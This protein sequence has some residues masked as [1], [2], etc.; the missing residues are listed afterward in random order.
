MD[1]PAQGRLPLALSRHHWGRDWP[2]GGGDP[3]CV[4]PGLALEA[5]P[6]AL[7][8]RGGAPHPPQVPRL[9]LHQRCA[10]LGRRRLCLL[11]RAPRWGQ[12]HPRDQVLPE[13][14]RHA[15]GAP[16]PHPPVQ[17]RGHRLQRGC[18]AAVREGGPHDPQWG[19]RRRAHGSGRRGAPRRPISPEPRG[20][21][22]HRRR[23]RG[24]RGRG[25]R[26]AHRRR[27]LRRRGR[28][29]THEP[30][31]P[32]AL[33]RLRGGLRFH[34]ALLPGAHAPE[35]TIRRPRDRRACGVREVRPQGIPRLGARHLRAHGR[36]R[37]LG[38]CR[39]QRGKLEAL[40]LEEGPHRSVR[41]QA[42]PRGAVC[43][44]RHRVDQFLGACNRWLFGHVTLHAVAEALLRAGQHQHPRPVPQQGAL[45]PAH[46][47]LLRGRPLP[48]GLLDL[49]DWRP[50]RPL[51]A[52]APGGR[53]LGPHR[54][55]A[56]GAIRSGEVASRRL[57]PNRRDGLPHGHGAHHHLPRGDP[58]G[59]HGR[60]RVGPADLLHG[61]CGQ[62][63]GRPLQRRPVRHPHPPQ[64]GAS[65]GGPTGEADADHAGLGRHVARPHHAPAADDRG[66]PGRVPRGLHPPR[67]PRPGAGDGPLR[68]P[69][70]AQDPPP[71]P[72][73]GREVRRLP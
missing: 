57:R 54:R 61:C 33:L 18:G 52:L 51:R 29:H 25:I 39:L 16:R 17:G 69:R 7:D 4:A 70:R 31:D 12:W 32:D 36:R 58:H 24:G 73:A 19:H 63:D 23:R 43:D 68:R 48:R 5:P 41:S 11:R 65:P 66:A 67:L 6:P 21:R 46:A 22:P 1:G 20:T 40:A 35:R 49:R 3:V 64:E 60:G 53:R 59:D 71:G 13:R 62:V 8:D 30:Y 72:G 15:R 2:G 10:G 56:R 37:G 47:G 45:R 44:R 55:P 34:R 42:L 14:R 27:A 50:E 26:R 9:G 38:R 28:R